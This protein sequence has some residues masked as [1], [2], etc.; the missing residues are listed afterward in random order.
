MCGWGGV[1]KLFFF[2]HFSF[3]FLFQ[4]LNQNYLE[5]GKLLRHGHQQGP[6]CGELWR[7]HMAG[8]DWLRVGTSG[9]GGLGC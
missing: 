9:G 7:V 5:P 4:E 8:K 3:D 1:G 6:S 2:F